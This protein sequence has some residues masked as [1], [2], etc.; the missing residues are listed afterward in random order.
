MVKVVYIYVYPSFTIQSLIQKINTFYKNEFDRN[1]HVYFV[2]V[3]T[4]RQEIIYP[5]NKEEQISIENLYK[6]QQQIFSNENN[7][8]HIQVFKR[9]DR[10]KY[11]TEQ[12]PV[13]IPLF[14][15]KYKQ[16]GDVDLQNFRWSTHQ[17]ERNF[18]I[19][20]GNLYENKG[21]HCNTIGAKRFLSQI[22]FLQNYTEQDIFCGID[23]NT[24]MIRTD[25]TVKDKN[26][27][28][29]SYG[30]SIDETLRLYHGND[31]FILGVEKG[32]LDHASDPKNR[33][34]HKLNVTNT[35]YKMIIISQPALK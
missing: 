13:N 33:S 32:S 22:H 27:Q 24:C 19:L 3:F 30:N 26:F 18:F 11:N 15:E 16:K 10:S 7:I 9:F 29:V 28:R 12:V 23:F 8:D 5:Y 35:L 2:G 25:S 34:E 17:I 6:I 14:L 31:K 1:T 20:T 21:I 4:E